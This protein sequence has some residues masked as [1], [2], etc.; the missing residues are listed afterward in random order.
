M[1]QKVKE[2]I[3]ALAPMSAKIQRIVNKRP[4]SIDMGKAQTIVDKLK[5]LQVMSKSFGNQ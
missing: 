4:E 1:S 2:A 3:D 5:T